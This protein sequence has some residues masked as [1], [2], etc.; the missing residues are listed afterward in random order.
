V[1]AVTELNPRVEEV[2][3][4]PEEETQYVP[5]GRN[6]KT[7]R[8]GVSLSLE[9]AKQLSATLQENVDAFVWTAA[10][11]P[12]VDP[13]IIMHKLSTFRDVRPV[14]QKKRKLGEE[15]RATA[16]EEIEKLLQAKFIR[17]A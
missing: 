12:G 1:V 11:I 16:R 6:D 14:A 5:L 10:D 3:V 15:T 9:D 8:M 2:R 13:S 7:T 17:E 4:E